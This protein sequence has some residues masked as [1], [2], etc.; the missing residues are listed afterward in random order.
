MKAR[1]RA[2]A[3]TLVVVLDE[4]EEEVPKARDT[5]SGMSFSLPRASSVAYTRHSVRS[6][7]CSAESVLRR[8]EWSRSRVSVCM[9]G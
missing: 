1:V 7:L 9:A 5:A 2:R 4:V 6:A 3:V 8:P